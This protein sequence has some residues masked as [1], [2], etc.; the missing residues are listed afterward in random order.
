MTTYYLA[1]IT[2]GPRTLP[3]ADE[4]DMVEDANMGQFDLVRETEKLGIARAGNGNDGELSEEQ[5]DLIKEL[6][7]RVVPRYSSGLSPH[8]RDFCDHETCRR[9]L[10]ARSWSLT[11]AEEQLVSTL[12]WRASANPAGK[13]FWQSSKCLQNPLALC[14]RVVGWDLQGRPIGYTCFREAHDRFDPD[15]NMEHIELILEATAHV[16]SA[17]RK[18]GHNKTA[19]SRQAVWIVDFSGFA[20][21]DQNPRTALMTA[22]LLQHHPEMLSMIVLIDPPTIFNA[23]WR[24]VAPLL[25]ARVRNK[26]MFVK[27]KDSA[28]LLKERLGLEAAQWVAMETKDNH[29]KFAEVKKGKPP[30]RYWIPPPEKWQHD[31]RGMASYVQS[32]LYIK[33]P[34]DAYEERKANIE[35]HI[36][37]K[38]CAAQSLYSGSF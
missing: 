33:T 7:N 35:H 5:L 14:M 6:Y 25:D 16:I 11:K 21:R 15:A 34:G 10:V 20:L 29:D 26:I 27:V 31:A 30:K 13:E 24:M 36:A 23:L 38:P 28:D 8:D 32:D 1:L 12:K 9:Y 19:D 3:H 2:M 37:I 4:S 18:L 22:K 17:R